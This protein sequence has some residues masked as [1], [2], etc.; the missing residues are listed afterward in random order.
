MSDDELEIRNLVAALAQ[1]AD[2]GTVDEYVAL[3]TDDAVWEMPANPAN[4]VP[5]SN[6]TGRAEIAAGVHDRRAAGVQGP[7][8]A[9][10]HVVS[11]LRITMVSTDEATGVAYFQYFADTT[12][13][14]RLVSVGQYDDVFRRTADGWKVARRRI[15]LG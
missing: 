9:T 2:T 13:M 5:A 1:F 3:F 8:S 15:V 7:G 10:R 6:R 4:D 12:T 14:P 11:T